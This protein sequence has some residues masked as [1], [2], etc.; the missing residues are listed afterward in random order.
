[1]RRE[2]DLRAGG[3]PTRSVGYWARVTVGG[4]TFLA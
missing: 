1:M 3:D 2:E 4:V